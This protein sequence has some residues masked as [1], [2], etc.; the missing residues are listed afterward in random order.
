[1]NKK[2]LSI[3]IFNWRDPW[4]PLAG[5]AE[6]VTLK[7]AEY[8]VKQ[9][10]EVTWV[11]GLYEDAE[12][13]EVKQGILYLRRGNSKTLFLRAWWI[14][15]FELKSE[16]D[17]IIDEVHGLPMFSPLWAKNK[18][19]IAL[20][21][22]VA[23]EIWSEMFQFP[24]STIG[25]WIE[26]YIFPK[27]YADIPFWVDCDSTK[28]D[29]IKLG[30]QDKQVTIIPCAIDPIP[31]ITTQKR[32]QQLTC[33]F[34]ARLVKMKGVEFAIQ[35]FSEIVKQEPE[36]ALWIVG[37]GE[38][39]YIEAL[40]TQINELGLKKQ[41]TFWGKVSETKKF[42]LMAQSHF[43]IHTSV[44]EGFGLTVLEA[45]SQSTPAAVFNVAALRDVV[46]SKNGIIVPFPDAIALAHKIVSIYRKKSTFQQMQ[47][48]AYTFSQ[49]FRWSTFTHQS[50]AILHL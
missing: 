7:H 21:H 38:P 29:L 47:K 27:V 22:E 43:L 41:V 16:P 17:V 31:K 13:D 36:A 32:Q 34:V 18:K 45:N 30:I 20:I 40:R 4:D 3:V 5:G 33:I 37:S 23:Q 6:R 2:S 11:S 25:K 39:T 26:K 42:E 1:M 35:A 8:W 12:P 9:G 14:F 10:H 50:E 44:R 15:L 48:S 28:Q 24:V 49:R 19:I 46:N